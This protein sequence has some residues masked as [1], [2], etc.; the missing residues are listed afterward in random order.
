[1]T[2]TEAEIPAHHPSA[3]SAFPAALALLSSP[4]NKTLCHGLVFVL[5]VVIPVVA[6]TDEGVLEEQRFT[7]LGRRQVWWLMDGDIA[8]GDGRRHKCPWKGNGGGDCRAQESLGKQERIFFLLVSNSILLL[9]TS[10]TVLPLPICPVS[11]RSF[12]LIDPSP[13]PPC[14]KPSLTW[15]QNLIWHSRCAES[16]AE[17]WL[18]KPH[19]GWS[20]VPSLLMGQQKVLWA[21]LLLHGVCT[22]AT[23]MYYL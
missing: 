18:E 9:E 20:S 10:K 2:G 5:S 6:S 21:P 17:T 3:L 11:F 13:C 8:C 7:P 15:P 23:G 12:P 19:A 1:M 22:V 14:L 4:C 16:N